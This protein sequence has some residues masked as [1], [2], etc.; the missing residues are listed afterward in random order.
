MSE[1]VIGTFAVLALLWAVFAFNSLIKSRN[2]TL[3]A[4]SDIDVQLQR[5][6]DLIP[7]LVDAVRAYASYEKVTLESVTQLR[8]KAIHSSRVRE[9][10]ELESG[11]ER[12]MHRLLAVA[13]DYPELKSNENFAKLQ[14]DL[15]DVEDHIQFA[16]RFYNGAV[17]KLNT[18][19]QSFPDVL[20]ARLFGFAEAEFFDAEDEA[21]GRIA[22]NL[23]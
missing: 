16:R 9:I 1:L 23:N 10:A 13:E 17:R 22:V 11:I 2:L 19:V 14:R 5:R 21:E 12:E 6:H 20:V 8:Q 4:W 7:K 18:R 15:I 3:A